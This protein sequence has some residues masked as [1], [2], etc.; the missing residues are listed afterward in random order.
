[1]NSI[2]EVYIYNFLS[3][4][5]SVSQQVDTAEGKECSKALRQKSARALREAS[6]GPTKTAI[7]MKLFGEHVGGLE[8]Q[9]CLLAHVSW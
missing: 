6:T 8:L 3:S 5:T 2:W 7:D 4:R 1:M 9:L